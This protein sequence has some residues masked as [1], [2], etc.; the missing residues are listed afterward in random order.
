M[1]WFYSYV[2]NDEEN[3]GKYPEKKIET[4]LI[5]S[6]EE[7]CHWF[8]GLIF[9]YLNSLENEVMLFYNLFFSLNIS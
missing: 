3:M 6:C 4:T 7:N 1:A 5:V 9:T 2:R 8:F